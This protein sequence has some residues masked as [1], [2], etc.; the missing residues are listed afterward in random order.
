MPTDMYYWSK[1]TVSGDDSSTITRARKLIISQIFTAGNYEYCVYWILHQDGVIQLEIKLTGI[2]STYALGPGESA[3][4]YGAEVY[5][6]VNAH[7]H[8]H[9]FCLRL[10]PSI[11]GHQNTVFE[12]DAVPSD[13]PLGSAER[14]GGRARHG[15]RVVCPPTRR[16]RPGGWD[17]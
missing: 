2:L 7:N 1:L 14:R 5:P 17:V 10:D 9:L 16:R 8:Q 15:G 4:P 12:V 11:D 13:A 6:G 3:A